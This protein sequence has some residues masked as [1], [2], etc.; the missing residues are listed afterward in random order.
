MATWAY[1]MI[2]EQLVEAFARACVRAGASNSGFV[3]DPL[4]PG[5]AQEV[6]YFKGVMLARLAGVK[7]SFVPNAMVQPRSGQAVRPFEYWG[8][9]VPP[10]PH[11]VHKIHYIKGKWYLEFEEEG[12]FQNGGYSRYSA[13][14]FILAPASVIAST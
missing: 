3:L 6:Q 13:D 11:K 4:G 1:E 2:D 12:L 10:G 5:W 14:E 9:S 7:P 8:R